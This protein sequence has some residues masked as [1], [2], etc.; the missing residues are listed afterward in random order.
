MLIA[1]TPAGVMEDFFAEVTRLTAIPSLEP[2]GPLFH[3]HG[4]ELLG[5]PLTIE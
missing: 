5:P 1:F 3:R 4:M 2:L